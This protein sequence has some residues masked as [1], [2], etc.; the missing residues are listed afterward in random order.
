LP[1]QMNIINPDSAKM[2][3][4]VKTDSVPPKTNPNPVQRNP[5]P[6]KTTA[7]PNPVKPKAVM[8]RQ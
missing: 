2:I 4:P 6:V 3:A 7:R 5:N 1:G 8:K